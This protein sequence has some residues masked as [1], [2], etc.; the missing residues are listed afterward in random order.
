MEVRKSY[1]FKFTRL[2]S[3]HFG[4][5]NTLHQV[6]LLH[7]DHKLLNYI[8]IV[9]KSHSLLWHIAHIYKFGVQ[10]GD[11]NCCCP[12]LCAMFTLRQ[13]PGVFSCPAMRIHAV[14]CRIYCMILIVYRSRWVTSG[15]WHPCTE[16]SPCSGHQRLNRAA[17]RGILFVCVWAAPDRAIL[18]L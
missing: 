17:S 12:W 16:K 2:R 5:N 6:A 4:V 3:F 1:R 8:Y 18:P 15:C 13:R 11:W 14:S 9:V 7:G 10:T